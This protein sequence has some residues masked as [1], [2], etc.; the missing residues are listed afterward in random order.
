M[1]QVNVIK[2]I[3]YDKTDSKVSGSKKKRRLLSNSKVLV[4]KF[5]KEQKKFVLLKEL[6]LL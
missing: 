6:H 5:A 2:G 3:T 4:D 1:P